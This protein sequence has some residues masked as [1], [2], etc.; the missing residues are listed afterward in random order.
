MKSSLKRNIAEIAIVIAIAI[1]LFF[2]S[3]IIKRSVSDNDGGK[4]TAEQLVE[5]VTTAEALTESGGSREPDTEAYTQTEQQLLYNFRRG[6]YLTEHF[7]K[8]GGEFGYKTEQEYLEGANS[9]ITDKD[10]LCK[11]EEEDGD[12]VFFQ[13]STGSIVFVSADGYIRTYFKPTDGI[14]YFNRQ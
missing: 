13:E 12:L 5:G 2:G 7:E 8:H 1:V 10:S 3:R 14:D 9:V 11:T 4:A 6:E